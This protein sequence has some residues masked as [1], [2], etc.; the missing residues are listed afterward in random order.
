MLLRLI[1]IACFV[2]LVEPRFVRLPAPTNFNIA[3]VRDT[4]HLYNPTFA[5][6]ALIVMTPTGSCLKIYSRTKSY[7]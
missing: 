5:G 7:K 6:V 3:K 4:L 1:H 2:K